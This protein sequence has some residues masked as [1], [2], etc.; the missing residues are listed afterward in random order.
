MTTK[1]IIWCN[2]LLYDGYIVD[3]RVGDS[4]RKRIE[5]FRPVQFIEN[6]DMDKL[7][8][9]TKGFKFENSKER[10]RIFNE[11]SVEFMSN[12]ELHEDFDLMSPFEDN[13]EDF[14]IV[15]QIYT[16]L[17]CGSEKIRIGDNYCSNCS[18][19]VDWETLKNRQI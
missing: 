14:F 16:C 7:E 15:N 18:A 13:K 2:V 5:D 1:G 10:S 6:I 3:W 19:K 4:E 8:T 12:W 17:E 11:K 9:E